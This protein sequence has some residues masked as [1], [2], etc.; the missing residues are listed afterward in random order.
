MDIWC[1]DAIGHVY[2]FKQTATGTPWHCVFRSQDLG[3][4]P[5]LYNQM[6]VMKN[7]EH[8]TTKLV[9]VSSGYVMAFSVDPSLL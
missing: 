8:K 9:L 3:A 4:C 7:S 1:T 6:Y 2:L 5:G